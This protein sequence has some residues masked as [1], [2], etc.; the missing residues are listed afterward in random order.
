MSVH[1]NQFPFDFCNTE[2]GQL[3]NDRGPLFMTKPCLHGKYNFAGILRRNRSARTRFSCFICYLRWIIK[4]F[5]YQ[6]WKML[7]KAL[8]IA[9]KLTGHLFNTYEMQ[10]GRYYFLFYLKKTDSNKL[11]LQIL[12]SFLLLF[13]WFI[14]CHSIMY[15]HVWDPIV[16]RDVWNFVLSPLLNNSLALV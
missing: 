16:V 15:S 13:L 9:L 4:S 10:R 11:T 7:L 6:T 5:E 12:L 14:I 2:R 3:T 8:S 1:Q